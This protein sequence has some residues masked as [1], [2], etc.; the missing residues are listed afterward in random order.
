MVD[1]STLP[2]NKQPPPPHQHLVALL[3][4]ERNQSRLICAAESLDELC[5]YLLDK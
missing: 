4:E 3:F 1:D 2:L 5:D